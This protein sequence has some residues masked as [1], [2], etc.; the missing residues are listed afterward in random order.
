MRSEKYLKIQDNKKVRYLQKFLRY[1]AAL[2]KV[3]V[4]MM[5]EDEDWYFLISDFLFEC[6]KLDFYKAHTT[7][8]NSTTV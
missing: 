8:Y 5:K 4:L 2:F 3:D 7:L 1:R 6:R